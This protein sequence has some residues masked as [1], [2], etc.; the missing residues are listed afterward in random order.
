M[1]SEDE[2]FFTLGKKTSREKRT[3]ASVVNV[4][5]FLDKLGNE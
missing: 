2:A 3:A 5:K 1:N 4:L